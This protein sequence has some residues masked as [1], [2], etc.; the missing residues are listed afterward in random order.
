MATN[1]TSTPSSTTPKQTKI[2]VYCGSSPG[3]KPEHVEAAREL[4][5]LMAANNIALVYGGGT[6]GLM[7]EVAKTLVSLSGPDSVHGIIPE[8]LVR[9]ER[10][11]T[12]TSKQLHS[13]TGTH[14]A[15]P[16][17]SVFG[18]TT[19]VKDMHTRKRLMAQ[20]VIDGGPGSGFIA[21]SGGYGTLEELF[22]TATWNQ[23]G[24]HDKGICVLNINGFYDG[25]L[26]WIN[27]SVQEGFIHGDNK[28]I[29]AEAKTPEEAIIAL[30]EYKVSEAVF[31]LSWNNQ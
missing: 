14:M 21:L 1:G 31:K 24:I 29:V 18:R 6:V 12:Y 19:I 16:E 20:E 15:V 4:A 10:D 5:R 11:P 28:R 30:R 9:Y 22:E 13:E 2:C 26:S 23:L 17:E 7:G 3:N 8:A 27:K 25:I